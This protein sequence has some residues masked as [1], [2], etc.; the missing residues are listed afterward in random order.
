MAKMILLLGGTG[1]IGQAFASELR[2]RDWVFRTV[3]RR[4]VDY[5]RYPLLS[6]L[7]KQLKPEFVVNCAGFTG[8]P[9]VDACEIARAD[10]LQGNTLLPHTIA[11]ACVAQGV[12]WGH[13]S[14]GCVFAGSKVADGSGNLR[15]E[16]NLLKPELKSLL[17]DHRE[18]FHG[19]VEEDALIGKAL[20]IYFSI[21]L[22]RLPHWYEVWNYPTIIRWNRIGHLLN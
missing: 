2:R 20:F 3:S 4:E 21:D 14:S 7:L 9:T 8:K 5:T 19:F 15:V 6:D 13:V 22:S 11:H 1:Y 10:T 16:K 17:L 18:L 12:P